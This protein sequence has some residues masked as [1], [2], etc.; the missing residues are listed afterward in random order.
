M[1]T[2]SQTPPDDEYLFNVRG[3]SHKNAPKIRVRINKTWH[4]VLVDS[5]SSVNT[6]NTDIA[7]SLG[8]EITR[9]STK[10]F[11]NA[12]ETPLTVQG[13]FTTTVESKLKI[14]PAT[15]VAV[16]SANIPLLSYETACALGVLKIANNVSTA[17]DKLK[18]QH[19]TVFSG[20]GKL[21]ANPVKLHIKR[22]V[23]PVNQAHRRIPF[24]KRKD[25]EACLDKRLKSDVI[26][27]AEGPTTWINPIVQ[28]PK[29][30]GSTRPCVDMRE[31]KKAIER[32]RHIIPKLDDIIAKLN[33]A[34]VFSKLDMN[35]GY[36]QLVLDPESRDIR[37]F[38]THKGLFRYKR[39]FFWNKCCSR[40][41]QRI[42]QKY[43]GCY[44]KSN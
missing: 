37:T 40:G 36:N 8:V 29:S 24:H 23:K 42:S 33:G 30:N 17:A 43:S 15:F 5:G 41:V 1:P 2:R 11:A 28:V 7:H 18:Q 13:Q 31:A 4:T 6:V 19:P 25:V 26:E 35:S 27:P 9:A 10:L 3:E 20:L 22:A 34:N 12:T 39:L 16:K 44:S 14:V 32:K 38:L 21:K